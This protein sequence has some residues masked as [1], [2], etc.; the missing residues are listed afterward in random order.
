MLEEQLRMSTMPS[1]I[2]FAVLLQ[3]YAKFSNFA[4]FCY[5]ALS[6]IMSFPLG[7][8]DSDSGYQE[9]V[10]DSR[11][12]DDD[13]DATED[14]NNQLVPAFDDP[15]L[16]YQYISPISNIHRP[17]VA[18]GIIF[19]SSKYS[20]SGIEAFTITFQV[21]N[22]TPRILALSNVEPVKPVC[23]SATKGPI[24]RFIEQSVR[25]VIAQY[26][27]E[28]FGPDEGTVL[29]QRSATAGNNWM[30]FNTLQPLHCSEHTAWIN[31]PKEPDLWCGDL[32]QKLVEG[33]SYRIDM[34][35]AGSLWG[36]R[37]M[38]ETIDCEFLNRDLPSF[39]VV[40]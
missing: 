4:S 13:S 36:R 9:E 39:E 22:L 34:M 15:G 28:V 8:E 31:N 20:K 12:G 6:K 17:R 1:N 25:G 23:S 3:Y 7:D 30:H 35:P 37:I 2:F 27:L 33:M 21:G 16:L 32:Q 26:R 38:T 18:L 40:E 24:L 5:A 14:D 11:D 10:S 29:F 19:S